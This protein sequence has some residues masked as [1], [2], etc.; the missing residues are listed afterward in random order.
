MELVE[1]DASDVLD[2]EVEFAGTGIFVTVTSVIIVVV[3]SEP[4]AEVDGDALLI[5]LSINDCRSPDVCLDLSSGV[6]DEVGSAVDAG[7]VL[8]VTIW[9]L[10]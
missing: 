5:R 3:I 1:L 8:F 6:S 10:I 9:R 7:T 2:Q 4:D